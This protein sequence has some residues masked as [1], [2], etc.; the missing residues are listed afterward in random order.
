MGAIVASLVQT[1]VKAIVLVVVAYG[2]IVFGKKYKDNKDA[3]KAVEALANE[4][5]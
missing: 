3:K 4:T 5:K 1:L 2:G